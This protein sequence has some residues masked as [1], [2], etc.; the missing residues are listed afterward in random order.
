[1][2]H[3]HLWE[4]ANGPIPADHVLKCLSNDK[5]NSDPSNWTL[6]P[7]AVMPRLAGRHGINYDEAPDELKPVLMQT[8][9]TEHAAREARRRIGRE[10]PC[11]RHARRRKAQRARSA[12]GD[13]P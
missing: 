1:M 4:Q 12:Q 7:K 3:R 5:S 6:V 8:A 2:K 11:Q 9:L 10:T 13:I